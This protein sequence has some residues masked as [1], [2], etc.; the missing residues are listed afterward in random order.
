[1]SLYYSPKTKKKIHII[2][3]CQE[4]ILKVWVFTGTWQGGNVFFGQNFPFFT[5]SVSRG[6]SVFDTAAEAGA[7]AGATGFYYI[8]LI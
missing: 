4:E 3:L 1:M 5:I 7:G 2:F 6:W 8:F